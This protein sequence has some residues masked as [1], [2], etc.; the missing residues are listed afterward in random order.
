MK[1]EQLSIFIENKKGRVS[2]VANTLSKAEINM[3]AFSLSENSEFGMM[4]IIVS[5][6]E[7]AVA[8]LRENRFKVNVTEVLCLEIVDKPGSMAKILNTLS[9]NDIFIE[10]MYAFTRSSHAFVVI[11]PTNLDL[12]AEILAAEQL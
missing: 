12:A 4:R 8:I 2:D 7:K 11:K 10:Y 1:I 6:S 5:D 9:A 3:Q